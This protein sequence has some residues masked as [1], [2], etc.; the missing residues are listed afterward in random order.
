VTGEPARRPRLAR[1]VTLV[2][3]AAVVVAV[4]LAVVVAVGL[5]RGAYDQQAREVL[6]REALLAAQLLERPAT[7][8]AVRPRRPAGRLFSDTGVVLVRV[9]ADGRSTAVGGAVMPAPAD[10]Q[11]AAAGAEAAATRELGGQRYLV[12]VQPVGADGGV[13]LLQRAADAEAVD[14][15]ALRRL[16]LALLVGLLVAVVLGVLLAARLARPL[17]RAAESARRLAAGERGLRLPLEGPAE[18]AELAGSLNALNAA[19]ATSERRQARFLL[20]VSHEL[21]TPLTAVRGFAE[22]LADEVATGPEAAH[23]GV[24]I[25]AEAERLERLV[26]DLLDLAR[27]GADDFRLDVVPVDLADLTDRAA[28]VWRRRTDAEGVPLRVELPA[29]PVV[30]TTDP[31]RVRQVLDGLTEN[32]LRV[33]PAGQP[34]VLSVTTDDTR[35]QAVLQ[36]RDGG[37]GLTD[38]DLAVAFEQSALYDRYRGVRRVGTGLGLALA[39]GLVGRLGGAITAGHAPEGGACFTVRLPLP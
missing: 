37:P 10:V 26:D 14:R 11:A 23:A 18:A 5:V 32:A 21:R 28:Q 3:C 24:V 1:Q 17:V 27:L 33:T 30:V 22:A 38:D 16:G 20:S 29:A 31:G 7:S 19:L 39:A 34:V 36:V 6:H 9:R 12:E 8:Q 13:V 2:V 25:R 15:A 4:V 35:R